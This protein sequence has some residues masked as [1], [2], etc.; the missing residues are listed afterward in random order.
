M[1]VKLA[2]VK[3]Y[4][5][6]MS[7]LYFTLPP[8]IRFYASTLILWHCSLFSLVAAVVLPTVGNILRNGTNLHLLTSPN[9]VDFHCSHESSWSDIYAFDYR[10]C[11]AAIRFM[12][13]TEMTEPS[14]G[15][16]LQEFI[17][18]STSPS[19]HT[20]LAVLTPRKYV[21]GQEKFLIQA[22]S[23]Y[24]Q[25]LCI[26]FSPHYSSNSIRINHRRNFL[27]NDCSIF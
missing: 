18:T 21:T 1:E 7:N 11:F 25:P 5:T 13:F 2:V 9:M 16:R 3:A 17:S 8:T 15:T 27:D 6:T 10:D 23:Y 4:S 14:H 24:N 12:M 20:G 19:G 26:F 22:H